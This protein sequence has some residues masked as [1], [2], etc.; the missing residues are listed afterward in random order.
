[1]LRRRVRLAD[2]ARQAQV[3]PAAASH[4]LN[5]R[6]GVS[7]ET[8]EKVRQ[9][10]RDLGYVP[11]EGARSMSRGRTDTWGAFFEGDPS[12]WSA[13]LQGAISFAEANGIR[14]EAHRMPPLDRRSGVLSGHLASTRLDGLLLL[15]PNGSDAHL[16]DF[17]GG[18]KPV[19]IAGRRSQ[20]F[21]SVEI[22]DRLA[23]EDLLHQLSLGGK[24]PVVLVATR[25]QVAREDRRIAA[26]MRSSPAV[27][28]PVDVDA[29]ESGVAA[30][31]E[32]LRAKASAVLCLAGDSTAWGILRECGLRRISV[33]G[34]LAVAG[35]GDLPFSDWMSPELTT[36][37]IP[38]E[39]LGLRSARLLHERLAKP[40]GERVHRTLDAHL[41]SRRSA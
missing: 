19:V 16:R 39:E 22:H 25:D 2:V 10:A 34:E 26:W 30:L 15:D 38:W 28:V 40:L 33:P 1:M 18:P 35:W 11:H 36:V 21:D 23:Q 12:S 9:A 27:L 37:R 4:A 31:G 17:R 20:W 8:R 14:M 13:W 5:G 6:P 32:I 24:R 29:P 41:V 3:S 7:D